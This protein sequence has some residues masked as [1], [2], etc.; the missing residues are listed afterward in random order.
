MAVGGAFWV[1]STATL[2]AMGPGMLVCTAYPKRHKLVPPP[3]IRAL[4][5]VEG[6]VR[7][8]SG[9]RRLAVED[10]EVVDALFC[11][12]GGATSLQHEGQAT[13]FCSSAMPKGGA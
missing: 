3:T 7:R 11:L 12:A 5:L 2:D 13:T 8:R 6:E 4:A 10:G 1:S 9:D